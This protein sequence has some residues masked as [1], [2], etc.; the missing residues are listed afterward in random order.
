MKFIKYYETPESSHQLLQNF[1]KYYKYNSVLILINWLNLMCNDW[2][3]NITICNKFSWQSLVI[4]NNTYQV[5]FIACSMQDQFLIY[6]V[7]EQWGHKF[8][9]GQ[10]L[11]QMLSGIQSKPLTYKKLP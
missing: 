2:L 8:E 9:F 5:L 7:F 4:E 1:I 11:V 6:M 3:I 10:R